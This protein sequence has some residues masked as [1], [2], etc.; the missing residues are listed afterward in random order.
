M[1]QSMNLLEN[2]IQEGSLKVDPEGHIVSKKPD[3]SFEVIGHE[4]NARGN[5]RITYREEGREHPV[6]V[7]AQRVAWR[8]HHGHWPPDDMSVMMINGDKG[9]FRRENLMLVP[10]GKERRAKVVIHGPQR[11]PRKQ[12]AA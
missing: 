8:I 4:G 10:R 2:R 3:G 7:Q 11:S 1:L 5:R 12:R 6:S 9:D